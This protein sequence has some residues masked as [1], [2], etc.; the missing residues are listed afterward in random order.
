M[1]AARHDFRKRPWE[2]AH[3]HRCHHRGPASLGAADAAECRRR[4][5]AR[6]LC[7]RAARAASQSARAARR[8]RGLRDRGAG[9][10]G[11]AADRPLGRTAQLRGL[12]LRR[13]RCARLRRGARPAL[14]DGSVEETRPRADGAR[15]RPDTGSRATAMAQS[16]AVPRRHVPR[17]ACLRLGRQARGRSVRRRRECLDR[18]GECQARVVAADRVQVARLPAR[19]L[20]GRRRGA[21]PASRSDAQLQRRDRPCAG[22]LSAAER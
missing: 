10:T 8:H 12:D 1:A 4:T 20:V 11:R 16:R 6:R 17:M 3:A 9:A 21:H 5:F 7:K 19:G 22:A 2:T 13:V 18:A 14:A 15:L